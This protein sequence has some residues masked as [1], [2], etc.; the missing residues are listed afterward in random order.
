[1][2]RV[3]SPRRFWTIIAVLVV[4]F[5]L[6]IY[7]IIQLTITRRPALLEMADKQHNL[8]IKVPPLRGAIL[9]RHGRELATNLKVPSIFAIPRMMSRDQKTKVARTLAPILGMEEKSIDEKLERDKS[10]VWLKRRVTFTVEDK[11]RSLELSGVGVMDEYRRFYPQGDLLSHIIGFTNID[12]DGLEGIELH[13]NKEL[14]GRSGKRITKRDALGREI[15]ALESRRVPAVNGH[16][17]YL[18]IDQ[19]IQYVTE[20]SLD[21]AFTQYKAKGAFAV[22]MEVKTG[23]ILA[24]ANRPGYDPNH[25]AKFAAE[26]RRNRAITDMYEPGSVFKIVAASGALNENKVAPDTMFYCE[27]GKYHYGGG[28][29]LHDVHP[30]G[31]LSFEDVIAK[32]SNIGTVKIAAALGNDLF[33]KYVKLFGF[34]QSTGVDFPGEAPGFI[35]SVDKWSKTSPY[36]IPIGQ[37]VMVTALQMVRAMSVIAN[38]GELMKPYLID[39]VQDEKGVV[40]YQKAPKVMHRVIRPEVAEEMQKILVRVVDEGTGTKAKI[41]GIPVGGKTG[42]AQKVLPNG[43]GYSHS[44]FMAS[45]VGFA[46]GDHP[47]LA[48]VV[49]LDDPR[50]QY[51][52]GVVAAPVFKEVMEASLLSMGYI[53]ATAEKLEE[54][55]Q[56]AKPAPSAPANQ[57]KILKPQAAGKAVQ[58]R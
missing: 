36:N 49:V 15:M 47:E 46:P 5:S 42:T 7:Q 1:M 34:G 10:F 35:R 17:I 50:G 57:P 8:S 12:N 29:V 3:F 54:S 30:Y 26:N 20:R 53:P 6:V 55:K 28:R 21:R 4:L 41:P 40:L 56:A 25:S 43:R 16:Q 48:M 58:T 2:A 33:Y 27:N 38:G 14:A 13:H 32:S 52:G 51:Y 44:N 19:Y 31:R 37:E 22:V 45:F 11:I 24:I 39:R 9:D 18:T 23:K